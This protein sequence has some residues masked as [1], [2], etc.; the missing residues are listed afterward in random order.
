MS[1]LM[2]AYVAVAAALLSG[3]VALVADRFPAALR[4]GSFS[5][6]GVCGVAAVAAGAEVM[7]TGARITSQLPFG[8]P[9]LN[10][11]L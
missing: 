5:I 10:W 3:V 1:P 7:S 2:L 9:W 6:L 8:L 11:H 4:V